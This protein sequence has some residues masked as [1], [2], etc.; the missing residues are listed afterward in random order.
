MAILDGNCIINDKNRINHIQTKIYKSTLR[1]TFSV[2]SSSVLLVRTI[3]IDLDT[4]PFCCCGTPPIVPRCK[5]LDYQGIYP[6]GYAK[7]YYFVIVC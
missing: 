1:E 5:H 4:F 2:R 7:N 3:D 6:N